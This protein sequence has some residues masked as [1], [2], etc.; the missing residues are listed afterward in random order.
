MTP[1]LEEEISPWFGSSRHQTH[2]EKREAIDF[3]AKAQS[4]DSDTPCPLTDTH[5]HTPHTH[6]ASSKGVEITTLNIAAETSPGSDME[7]L[8]LN[9]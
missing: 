4:A 1:Q 5:K 8:F 6:R 3:T 7:R 9:Q 2:P